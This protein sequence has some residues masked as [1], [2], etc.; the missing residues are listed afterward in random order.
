MSELYVDIFVRGNAVDIFKDVAQD[1]LATFK[2]ACARGDVDAVRAA[3]HQH[4]QL[5]RHASSVMAAVSNNHSTVCAALLSVDSGLEDTPLVQHLAADVFECDDAMPLTLWQ[6]AA[7]AAVL[8]GHVDVLRVLLQ[9]ESSVYGKIY[10]HMFILACGNNNRE[11]A[12]V[13]AEYVGVH[14]STDANARILRM[15]LDAGYSAAVSVLAKRCIDA[16]FVGDTRRCCGPPL[17]TLISVA[18][19]RLTVLHNSAFE[20]LL[21]AVSQDSELVHVVVRQWI[22]LCT[23]IQDAQ[24]IVQQTKRH[25]VCFDKGLPSTLLADLVYDGRNECAMYIANN[26]N[27]G[28]DMYA[29]LLIAAVYTGQLHMFR[30]LVN[31]SND[32]S[33]KNAAK[34]DKKTITA[35]VEDALTCPAQPRIL[36]YALDTFGTAWR[37][38]FEI[39]AENSHLDGLMHGVQ[40]VIHLLDHPSNV[41]ATCADKLLR[42]A[43]AAAALSGNVCGLI[44]LLLKS[45][46]RGT[47]G[48]HFQRA[49]QHSECVT[50]VACSYSPEMAKQWKDS[51]FCTLEYLPHESLPYITLQYLPKKVSSRNA[52]LLQQHQWR[53][54]AF[55]V[56]ARGTKA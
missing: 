11:I 52:K 56:L 46:A 20:A 40:A 7:Q 31:M 55:L 47:T 30:E 37:E 53:R 27:V 16:R 9:Q 43:V 14:T 13:L 12:T 15:L 35:V 33:G 51:C 5:A 45:S 42:R 50:A 39:G 44:K 48:I 36:K 1:T 2:A 10:M 25:A 28:Q 17:R 29:K 38:A 23:S 34:L 22:R 26:V 18:L 21:D 41:A 32:T 6:H 4:P 19:I 24:C 3:L 54:R 8:H 49:P